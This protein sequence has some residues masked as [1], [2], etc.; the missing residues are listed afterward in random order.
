MTPAALLLRRAL[1]P[2]LLISVVTGVAVGIVSRRTNPGVEAALTLTVPAPVRESP[3]NRTPSGATETAFEALQSAEIFAETLA[4]WLTSPD[5]VAAVYARAG[6]VFQ[7][8][9]VR[10]LGRAFTAV[11]RGGPVVDVHFRAPSADEARAIARAVVTEI[12]ERT[13][14]FSSVTGGPVFRVTTSE[15]LVIP[16]LVSPLLRALVGGVV[17]FVLG[18]N[19]VLLG[20]FLRSP[21]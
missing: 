12:Q 13:A 9:T 3:S 11:K 14:A 21:S 18:L 19:L 5:F 15:P 1:G 7:R 20:D 4:G 8:V 17:A 10:R 16:V 2:L 6:V